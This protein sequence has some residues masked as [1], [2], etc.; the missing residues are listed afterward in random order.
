MF[1]DIGSKIKTL[2][3]VVCWIGIALTGITGILVMSREFGDNVLFGGAILIVG[4]L[5]SWIGSS[6]LYGFGEL[7][8]KTTEI[9]KNTRCNN[10][11]NTT[12]KQD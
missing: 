5:S 8:E 11:N 4:P 6:F 2:A 3:R 7:I 9:A 10:I 12:S 1:D